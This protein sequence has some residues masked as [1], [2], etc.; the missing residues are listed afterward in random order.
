MEVEKLVSISGIDPTAVCFFEG[1]VLID[2]R[3]CD[4]VRDLLK[5]Q[6]PTFLGWIAFDRGFE[7]VHRGALVDQI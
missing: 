7:V 2:D 1:L 5:G 3:L 4:Q 6:V